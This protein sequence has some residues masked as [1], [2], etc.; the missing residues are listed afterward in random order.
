HM[1]PE[2]WREVSTLDDLL[3]HNFIPACSVMVRNG[4]V[5]KFPD[6]YFSLALE[7]WP[8]SI[9]LALHGKLGYIDQVMADYRLHSEG[10]WTGKDY[11]FQSERTLEMLSHIRE[12]LDRDRALQLTRQIVR[13]YLHLAEWHVRSGNV[14]KARS[15][16][17]ALACRESLVQRGF[18]YRWALNV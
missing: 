10:A 2:Y 1:L 3:R 13:R 18:P 4:L 11:G 12:V 16:L 14:S 6:W 17:R 7:D 9:M 15:T 8:F 5:R